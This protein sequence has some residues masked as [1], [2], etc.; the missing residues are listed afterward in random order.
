MHLV[1][2]SSRLLTFLVP[3]TV[4]NRKAMDLYQFALAGQDSPPLPLRSKWTKSLPRIHWKYNTNR[5]EQLHCRI[6]KSL[7]LKKTGQ[8][9]KPRRRHEPKK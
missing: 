3:S 6:E 2:A 9:W 5:A 4:F 7:D 1:A 8:Q